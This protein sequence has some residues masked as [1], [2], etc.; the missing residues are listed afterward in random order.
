MKLNT[1]KIWIE[2]ARP[3]TLWASVAPV[4]IGTAMAYSDG[5]WDS[6]IATLTLLSAMMIQIGTNYANDYYDY[7]KGAD[8]KERIGPA[9]IITRIAANE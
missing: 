7:V 6:L 8:T 3:K 1:A 9:R 5:K 4:I 2:A